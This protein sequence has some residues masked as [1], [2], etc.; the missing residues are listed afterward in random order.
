VATA[1]SPT[2]STGEVVQAWVSPDLAREL[3]QLAEQERR[4]V[5]AVIRLALEDQLRK[6]GRR[7]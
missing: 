4:S 5:S 1:E 7:P 2:T 3:K 6:E